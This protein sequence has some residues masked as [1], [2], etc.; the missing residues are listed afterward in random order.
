ATRESLH[1]VAEHVLAPARHRVTGR[2]GLVAT[3]GGFGTPTFGDDERVRVDGVDLVVEHGKDVRRAPLT[4]LAD[5]A[6][7]ADVDLGVPTGVY[8]RATTAEPDVLLA[9]DA[10]AAAVLAAWMGFSWQVLG[11]LSDEFSDRSPSA[12]QLWPEHFDMSIDFGDEAA[13]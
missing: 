8:T 11:D 10:G 5:A 3:P 12:L 2:I 13:G 6:R 9:V 7:F 4:T 1:K